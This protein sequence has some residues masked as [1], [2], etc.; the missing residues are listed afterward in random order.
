MVELFFDNTKRCGATGVQDIKL[1]QDGG[2]AL[3]TYDDPRG[4][5]F[6]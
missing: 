3:V 4:T 5:E 6:F 1:C 2:Y